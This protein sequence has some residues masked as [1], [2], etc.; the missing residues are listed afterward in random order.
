M[1]GEDSGEAPGR[2]VLSSIVPVFC[3]DLCLNLSARHSLPPS[4]PLQ[5]YF[6]QLR[7]HRG[8]FCDGISFT[9]AQP[10]A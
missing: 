2:L 10:R 9:P 3:V 7:A 1:I 4:L 8:Q 6:L 5:T